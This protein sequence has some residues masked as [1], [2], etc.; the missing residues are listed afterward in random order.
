MSPFFYVSLGSRVISLTVLGTSV[1]NLNEPPRALATSTIMWVRSQLH[2]FWAVVKQKQRGFRGLL[3]RW[4]S[5]TEWEVHITAHGPRLWNDLYCVEWDVKHYH[6]IPYHLPLLGLQP[7][8]KEPLMSV[9]RGHWPVR[10]QTYGYLSRCRYHRPL[11]G[12]KFHCL[13]TEA[14]VC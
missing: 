2:T 10:C 11:A 13:T 6:T 4:P 1:T 14:H 12:T 7:V 3:C 5:I 9:T 8:D